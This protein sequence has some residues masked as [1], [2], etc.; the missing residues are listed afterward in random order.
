MG[1]LGNGGAL[2]QVYRNTPT[3]CIAAMI[4]YNIWDLHGENGAD[5]PPDEAGPGKTHGGNTKWV[6]PK[7]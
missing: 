3:Y 4:H 7:D 5:G 6:N 2:S 1:G